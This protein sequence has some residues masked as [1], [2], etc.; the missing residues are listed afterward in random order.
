MRRLTPALRHRQP[1]GD[2]D[3]DGDGGGGAAAALVGDE[4]YAN[5]GALAGLP[6]QR[7]TSTYRWNS[8]WSAHR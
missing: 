2:G 3:S 6:S 8:R 7:D 1:W 5:L 4:G